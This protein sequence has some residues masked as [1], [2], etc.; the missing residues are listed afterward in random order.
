ML[1]CCLILPSCFK[2]ILLI[3]FNVLNPNAI[4]F[5]TKV[6]LILNPTIEKNDCQFLSHRAI[7]NDHKTIG[8]GGGLSRSVGFQRLSDIEVETEPLTESNV[9]VHKQTAG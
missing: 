3:Q 7:Q 1:W 4:L 9:E 5:K 6:Q 2:L 8:F